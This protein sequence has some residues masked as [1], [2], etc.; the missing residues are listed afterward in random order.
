MTGNFLKDY[1]KNDSNGLICSYIIIPLFEPSGIAETKPGQ[2]RFQDSRAKTLK[3]EKNYY[4]CY[5]TFLA[6]DTDIS[7][8][9]KR[10]RRF[11]YEI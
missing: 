8:K 1:H 6:I 7:M 4:Y 11:H 2:E 10:D 9:Y 3:W 5:N